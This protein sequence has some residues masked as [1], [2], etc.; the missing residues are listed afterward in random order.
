M[1]KAL[2]IAG[3]NLRM[4]LRDAAGAFF[5]L[6]FPFLLILALGATFGAGSTPE[7]GVTDLGAGPLGEDL[8]GRL[9]AI[10][11]LDV[12]SFDDEA[13][14]RDAVER[15]AVEGGVVLPDGFDERVRGGGTVEI[16]YLAR[17][18]GG[19]QELRLAVEA[20]VEEQGVE[21]VAARF[22]VEEGLAT[23]LDGGLAAA[24]ST[25]AAAA[26]R[27]G[28]E[29]RTP[30]GDPGVSGFARGAAQQLVVYVFITSLSASSMLVESRRLGVSR[31]MLASP[32]PAR[33]V[34]AGEALGRYAIAFGQGA[35]ILV[36]TVVLFRVDWGNPLTTLVVLAL[37]ALA[38]TGAAML[39]GASLDNASQAG[40]LGVFLGLI[41]GALGG[42]MVPLEIFP[43][44]MERIAHLTPH[45]WAL[46]ALGESLARDAAPADVA[47]E[48]GVLAAYGVALLAVATALLRRTITGRS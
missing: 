1:R 26:P 27:V 14:L 44:V 25:A 23:D 10:E 47:A 20:A 30:G 34:L 12:R 11:R 4:L 35:L 46:D 33:T 8:R 38:G 48:L 28:V 24:R 6:V 31:R 3:V 29:V 18:T 43:P 41:L 2:A 5:V 40:A 32:T 22:L 13:S 17:P 37:F 7:L 42:G 15:G 16:A 39:M 19:G 36:G 9:E 45:A 21:L